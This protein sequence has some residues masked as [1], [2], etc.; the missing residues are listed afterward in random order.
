MTIGKAISK[1]TNDFICELLAS[2]WLS[3][4]KYFDVLAF[5]KVLPFYSPPVVCLSV[6]KV[7]IVDNS[8]NCGFFVF[9]LNIVWIIMVLRI[10]HLK[11]NQNCTTGSK[12]TTI[13]TMF[14]VHD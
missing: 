1:F 5:N 6:T 13:S 14:F 8:R 7:V 9:L 3:L 11:G 4:F 10:Q 12:V 2:F